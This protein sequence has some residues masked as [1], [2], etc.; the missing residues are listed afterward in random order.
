LQVR[1]PV[2]GEPLAGEEPTTGHLLLWCDGINTVDIARA[3]NWV[4]AIL[5]V[6]E[7]AKQFVY[8][9]FNP[10]IS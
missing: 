6:P 3:R 9:T 10:V 4:P 7:R 5:S 2:V 8:Q 1:W